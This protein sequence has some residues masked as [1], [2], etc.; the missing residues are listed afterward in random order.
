VFDVV[1]RIAKDRGIP[2]AQVALAWVLAN[3]AITSPIVGATKTQHLADAIA[4]LDVHLSRE[5]IDAMEAPY[6]PRAVS[7]VSPPMNPQPLK[8]SAVRD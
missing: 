5:E 7:G 1:S 2:R 8:L 4:A 6:V 3:P